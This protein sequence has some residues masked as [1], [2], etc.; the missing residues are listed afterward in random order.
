MLRDDARYRFC[1][2]KS[3]GAPGY[4]LEVIKDDNGRLSRCVIEVRVN[5][6]NERHDC[7]VKSIK[8]Y[9]HRLDLTVRDWV[10]RDDPNRNVELVSVGRTTVIYK[11]YSADRLV[12]DTDTMEFLDRFRMVT[13]ATL[14]EKRSPSR[15][16]N[17]GPSKQLSVYDLV[18][19]NYLG[20]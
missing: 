2:R 16:L 15:K 9:Y 17:K 13:E 18:I 8:T 12:Y 19:S 1:R 11:D 20:L 3:D 6:V 4:I 10:S 7:S 5:G 14:P